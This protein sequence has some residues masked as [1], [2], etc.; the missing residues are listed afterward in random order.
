MGITLANKLYWIKPTGEFGLIDTVYGINALATNS[1]LGIVYTCEEKTVYWYDLYANTK[2]TV[3][4]FEIE[5]E[6]SSGGAAYNSGCIYVASETNELPEDIYRIELNEDGKSA[7][8][9]AATNITNG[10]GPVN[11]NFGDILVEGTIDNETI[12]GSTKNTSTSTRYFWKFENDTIIVISSAEGDAL[13]L[14]RDDSSNIWAYNYTTG[15]LFQ[16]DKSTGDTSNTVFIEK[17]LFSD[18]G[19]YNC[20][21]NIPTSNPIT[22]GTINSDKNNLI[23]YPNP[24]HDYL[25]IVNNSGQD[26]DCINIYNMKGEKLSAYN[27]K[28]RLNLNNFARGIY[29]IEIK[30]DDFSKRTHYIL[31]E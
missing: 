9:D 22:I 6:M 1:D 29:L 17:K 4:T 27:P 31:K 14:S 21:F 24:T 5:G 16:L 8:S 28:E 19:E 15:Y 23:L 18:I 13:Q 12:Y 3:G 20:D 11:S 7:K 26:I 30:F 2:G 25:N 10:K